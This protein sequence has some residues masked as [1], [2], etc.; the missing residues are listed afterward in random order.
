[1]ILLLMAK[2]D[3]QSA[4]DS[5][6]SLLLK[7]AELKLAECRGVVGYAVLW[8]GLDNL[9]CAEFTQCLGLKK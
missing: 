9:M 5:L 1:M 3:H 6:L 8:I 4:S 2:I 7:T